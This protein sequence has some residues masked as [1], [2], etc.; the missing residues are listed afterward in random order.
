[1]VSHYVNEYD[2][3][4][5][6]VAAALASVLQ[7]DEPMLLDPEVERPRQNHADST[8]RRERSRDEP[9]ERRRRGETSGPTATY[10]LAVGRRHKVTPRQVVGAL[11][12]EGGLR[13]ED[14][15]RID[16]RADHTLVELP[17]KLPQEAWDALRGTRISGKLIELERE[18]ALRKPRQKGKR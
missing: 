7:G 3:P 6:D 13:R 10:R 11:A 12:N 9:L 18:R 16:I 1:V 8:G 4:E 5:V 2:V 14:F 15:G 17:A